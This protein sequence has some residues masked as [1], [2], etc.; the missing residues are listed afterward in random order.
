MYLLD[1]LYRPQPSVFRS[2]DW[3]AEWTD[4]Q[5]QFRKW[6][7]SDVFGE[8]YDSD[9]MIRRDRMPGGQRGLIVLASGVGRHLASDAAFGAR[10]D[11]GRAGNDRTGR[12]LHSAADGTG[13]CPREANGNHFANLGAPFQ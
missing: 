10:D 2:K 13:L 1:E 5:A 4:S 7:K 11:D 12:I 3:A 6:E 8:R 9:W